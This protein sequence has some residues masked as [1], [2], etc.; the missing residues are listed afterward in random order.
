MMKNLNFTLYKKMLFFRLVEKEIAKRYSEREMRCPTHLSIGQEA[1]SAAF[2]L[3]VN[4]KDYAVSSHRAHLHYLAKGGDL[5]KMIAE[6]YGKKTGCSKGKGGSMHLIDTNVNFMGSSAIVGNSIPVGTGLALS[7]KIKNDGRKSFIFFGDG[8]VE[9]GVFF[10]S[11]NFAA[12]KKIPAIF[13]C[14]NNLYSVYSS[15]KERQPENRKNYKMTR[16]IGIESYFSSGNNVFECYKCLKKAIR[17]VEKFKK[18]VFI[19]FL[20]Y[21]QIEHCGPNIDD[22]LNYRSSKEINFWKLKDPLILAKKSLSKKN[23]QL[24]AQEEKK[25]LLKIYNAFKF[26]KE[27]PKPLKRSIYEDIYA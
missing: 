6:I 12:V 11:I 3:L 14:E 1:V 8:A 5:K 20:T 2:S 19:E 22:H 17:Y 4:K 27:S 15:L 13:V 18:P 9:Q 10:E 25:F 21:R 24:V 26:A 16:A 23:N 7:S